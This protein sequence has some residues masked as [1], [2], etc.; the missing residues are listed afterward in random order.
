[1][2]F[3]YR[4][5]LCVFTCSNLLMQTTIS[6]CMITARIHE[7]AMA[8]H[9]IAYVVR[10]YTCL[11]VQL[12]EYVWTHSV[13]FGYPL[14]LPCQTFP[15]FAHQ[16]KIPQKDTFSICVQETKLKT[17][18]ALCSLLSDCW[19]AGGGGVVTLFS[20]RYFDLIPNSV[21]FEY[22]MKKVGFN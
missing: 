15:S 21:E 11:S 10:V 16:I 9:G 7:L 17:I 20:L 1:M 22:H 6:K 8:W 4:L 18:T 5:S 12:M 13:Q 14:Y 2:L 19:L 3:V